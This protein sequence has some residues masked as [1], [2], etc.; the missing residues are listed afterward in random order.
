MTDIMKLADA[1]ITQLLSDVGRQYGLH[2]VT[3]TTDGKARAALQS[4]IEALQGEV[5]RL[6]AFADL[7][8]A[9][10][11]MTT[12]VHSPNIEFSEQLQIIPSLW[13][14][15]MEECDALAAELAA[16][17]AVRDQLD[18]SWHDIARTAQLEAEALQAN[19]DELQ[20]QKPVEFLA[21]ATRF[22][23]TMLANGRVLINDLPRELAGRW[24]AF[25]AAENDCHLKLAAPKA[26]VPEQVEAVWRAGWSACRDAEYVG[27]EAEDEAWGMS[28][29]CA[30]A[31]WEN[32][33]PKALEPRACEIFSMG[34]WCLWPLDMYEEA[35]TR[36][37][38]VRKLVAE[39]SN[40]ITKG[41]P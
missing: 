14:K 3:A 23:T 37:W 2:R 8:V 6:K 10:Y 34:E 29:T 16:V 12:T 20:R 41:T 25:V 40:G 31:D 21:D 19:L 36:G 28:Q 22:K 1:Y 11:E 24:V 7:G 9:M 27:Q 35:K 17:R 5:E 13:A 30:S 26:L 38:Q 4:A 15:C 32:A 39:A 18:K 33:A